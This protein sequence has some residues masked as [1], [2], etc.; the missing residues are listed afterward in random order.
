MLVACV[1]DQVEAFNKKRLEVNV[2][3]FLSPSEIQDQAESGKIGFGEINNKNLAQEQEAIDNV[4]LGFKDGLFV[5]FI[6]DEE[7]TN[8]QTPLQLTSE[9]VIAFIRMTFLVGAYW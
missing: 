3:G 1:K 9:S 6:D 4:L 8:L 7:I 5:V 2:I